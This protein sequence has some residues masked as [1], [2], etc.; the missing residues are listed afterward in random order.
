MGTDH[1]CGGRRVPRQQFRNG[2]G[3]SQRHV[4]VDTIGRDR[5]ADRRGEFA[6]CAVPGAMAAHTPLR[7]DSHVGTFVAMGVVTGDTGHGTALLKT[8]AG[9]EQAILIPVD[10]DVIRV[11]PRGVHDKIIR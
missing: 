6:D 4:T 3:R 5:G 10:V 11:G 1:G 7:E 9:A 2:L 8:T